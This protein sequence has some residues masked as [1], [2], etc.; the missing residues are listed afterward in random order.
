MSMHPR[1]ERKVKAGSGRVIILRV[2]G[3][4]RR[5]K[6]I[7]LLYDLDERDYTIEDDTQVRGLYNLTVICTSQEHF[8][9]CS[10]KIRVKRLILHPR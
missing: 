8:C 4:S 7:L 2:V 5:E 6:G 10:H 9:R 1:W 3:V